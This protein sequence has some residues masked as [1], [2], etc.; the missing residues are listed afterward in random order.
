MATTKKITSTKKPTTRTTATK[1]VASNKVENTAK[2]TVT[3]ELE[4]TAE[5]VVLEEEVTKEPKNFKETDLIPCMCVFPGSVGMT[6]KRTRNVY[7]W[8]GMGSIEYVEFQDLRSEV[9]NKKSTYI[10]EPLIIISDDDFLD[11]NQ[12]LHELYSDYY[13]PDEIIEVIEDS[14]P[15]EM[16]EF[17]ENLPYK[18]KDNVKTI[19]STLIQ[20]GELDSIR[21]VKIIDKIFGTNLEVIS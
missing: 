9:L 18:L 4:N 10:Y 16:K 5:E 3:K 15:E 20:N 1:K 7:H 21:K 11:L 14:S 13:T 2:K 17:I 12:K 19:A 6:G 8:D